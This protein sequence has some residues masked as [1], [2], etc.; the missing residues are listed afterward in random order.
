MAHSTNETLSFCADANDTC[1]SPRRERTIN[2]AAVITPT[3]SLNIQQSR[4]IGTKSTSEKRNVHKKTN[5]KT[6]VSK[7]DALVTKYPKYQTD[8]LMKWMIQN[9]DNT[10]PDHHA[11]MNLSAQTGLTTSQ[12]INWT[13]NVRKRNIKATCEGRKKPHHFIDFLFLAQERDKKQ[14]YMEKHSRSPIKLRLNK[15]TTK[16]C[17]TST[18]FGPIHRSLSDFTDME[19]SLNQQ[20]LS[21][22]SGVVPSSPVPILY[23]SSAITCSIIDNENCTDML[24]DP[25]SIHDEVDG[26]LLNEFAQKYKGI[27]LQH[28]DDVASETKNND[29]SMNT[30]ETFLPFQ[31]ASFDVDDANIS[32]DMDSW[33]IELGIE[34][35]FS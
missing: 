19:H 6:V 23:K 4:E 8:I 20:A 21:L 2:D 34:R 9:K 31:S 7:N 28:D 17:A 22:S 12:I 33:A 13:T 24:D 11:I 32:E 3:S 35:E 18:F 29:S 26:N 16:D 1:F 30:D 5:T 25:M 10:C 14:Y 27:D 15:K